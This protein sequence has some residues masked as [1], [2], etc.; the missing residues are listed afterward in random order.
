MFEYRYLG[1]SRKGMRAGG[2]KRGNTR[3]GDGGSGRSSTRDRVISSPRGG[4]WSWRRLHAQSGGRISPLR[5]QSG[6]L[7]NMGGDLSPYSFAIH[8]YLASRC[9]YF[10]FLTGMTLVPKVVALPVMPRGFI[11]SAKRTYPHMQWSWIRQK[12]RKEAR[13]CS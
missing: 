9:C 7:V 2:S 5:C 4:E 13:K 3:R 8:A 12:V 10:L 11:V 6:E 1:V